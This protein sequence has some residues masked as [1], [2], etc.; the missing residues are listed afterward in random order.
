M[1]D[2]DWL[3]DNEALFQE[4][5]EILIDVNGRFSDAEVTASF[6]NDAKKYAYDCINIKKPFLKFKQI[7]A[8]YYLKTEVFDE[9]WRSYIIE[10]VIC[11]MIVQSA[12]RKVADEIINKT[13]YDLDHT[14]SLIFDRLKL[15]NGFYGILSKID[16]GEIEKDWDY[17]KV[18]GGLTESAD[19]GEET[20]HMQN[21][22]DNNDEYKKKIEELQQ[23][24]NLQQEKISEL[25]EQLKT[26]EEGPIVVEPHNKVRLELLR[27]LFTAAGADL[28]KSGAKANAGKLAEY[29]TG[30]HLNTCK[31]YLSNPE[32]NPEYNQYN[33]KLHKEEREKVNGF[34]T[35]TDIN[36]RL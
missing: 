10:A 33:P 36:I 3:L 19:N 25:E 15:I 27:Q 2:F 26:Y 32:L 35:I 8:Q 30:L 31:T 16:K 28:N 24:I 4:W 22:T 11:T 9:S 17:S 21:P 34:L 23:T 5:Y 7:V 18:D 12:G 1:K 13:L 29:I 14:Y 20:T 6:W